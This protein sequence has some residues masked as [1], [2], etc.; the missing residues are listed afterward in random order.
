[1]VIVAALLGSAA[2]CADS[3]GGS[4]LSRDA[5]LSKAPDVSFQQVGIDEVGDH[6]EAAVAGT[7]TLGVR[8]LAPSYAQG[9]VDN[10]VV[11]PFSAR[12]A[13][14]MVRAGA[15]GT[16]AHELDSALGTTDPKTFAALIG[17]FDALKGDPGKVDQ[18]NPPNPPVLNQA[19]A[20]FID[21]TLPVGERYLKTLASSYDTGVY[22]VDFASGQA[23]SAINQ[24]LAVNTGG[25]IDSTP[26]DDNSDTRMSL[27]STVFLAAA[28]AHPFSPGSTG[29]ASFTRADGSVVQADLMHQTT[30]GRLVSTVSYVAAQLPYGGGLAMQIVVPTE[31][32]AT[33]E[34]ASTI[35][36][37]ATDTVLSKVAADLHAARDESVTF[38]L[39]RWS[40][41]DSLDLKPVLTQM[42]ITTMFT[43]D[44]D[45]D[46][47]NPSVM[48]NAV[49]QDSTITVGEKG[50]VAASATQVDMMPTM[51][52]PG[53]AIVADHPFVYQIVDTATGLPLFMGVLADPSA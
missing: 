2:G 17:Q 42:G 15:G 16:T 12:V 51:L 28:W 3:S 20:A 37:V 38:T 44:A 9:H 1:M 35:A 8:L 27:L 50:T 31:K 11:S 33:S 45:L 48:V 10:V 29:Q 40:V 52:P 26:T 39:P 32:G 7:R 21:H 14:A 19:A 5:Q 25:L 53:P 4:E 24:W 23:R 6:L 41:T 36:S 13:L 49:A 22:P 30:T 34:G 46:E 43:A 47:I 18:Q